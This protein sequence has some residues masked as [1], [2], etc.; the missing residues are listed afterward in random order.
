M[1]ESAGTRL[2]TQSSGLN[3]GQYLAIN[4]ALRDSIAQGSLSVGGGAS[5]LHGVGPA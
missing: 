1:L 2:V 5:C 4:E 3:L